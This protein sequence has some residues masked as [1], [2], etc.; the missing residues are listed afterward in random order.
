MLALA[1]QVITGFDAAERRPW[2]VEAALIELSKQVGDLARHVMVA[3]RYYLADRDD[4]PRYRTDRDGIADELADILYCLIRIADHYGIDLARA[5]IKAR[6]A[7]LDY[8]VRR[9]ASPS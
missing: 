5:H 8:L 1:R 6:Q 2:T 7:E 4:D 3:E 9:D